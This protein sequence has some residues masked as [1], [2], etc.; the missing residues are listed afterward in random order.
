[1]VRVVRV[2]VLRYPTGA[3]VEFVEAQ[4]V[5]DRRMGGNRAEEIG[6]LDHRRAHQQSP[7]TGAM[8]P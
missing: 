3:G 1:M 6:S 4:E 2:P 5:E 7:M 8:N